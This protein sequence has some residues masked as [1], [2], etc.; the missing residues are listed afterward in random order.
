M[1]KSAE[2][3]SE[4][5]YLTCNDKDFSRFNVWMGGEIIPAADVIAADS[6]RNEVWCWFDDDD[7]KRR[8]NLKSGVPVKIEPVA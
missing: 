8:V 2:M 3:S 1:R 7:G 6:H 4:R 5:T